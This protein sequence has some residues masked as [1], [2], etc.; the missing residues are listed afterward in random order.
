MSL[1]QRTGIQANTDPLG[2]TDWD[3]SHQSTRARTSPDPTTRESRAAAGITRY[4][5][6]EHFRLAL[7]P[8]PLTAVG[9]HSRIP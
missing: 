1:A 2:K 9:G 7:S 8:P 6:P 5:V 3:A 4:L